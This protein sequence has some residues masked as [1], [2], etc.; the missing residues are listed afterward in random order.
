MATAAPRVRTWVARFGVSHVS[1]R[2]LCCSR[3]MRAAAASDLEVELTAPNG[4]RW[5]QPLGLFVGNEFVDSQQGHRIT[6][7]NPLYV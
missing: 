2:G 7:V 6:T 3:S 5:M 4:R 1:R